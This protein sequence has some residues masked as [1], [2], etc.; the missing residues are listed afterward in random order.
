M[1]CGL[2]GEIRFDGR[3][4]DIGAV[5]RMTGAMYDRGPDGFP[6]VAAA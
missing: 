2:S 4:A 5:D 6:P 3:A 1:M